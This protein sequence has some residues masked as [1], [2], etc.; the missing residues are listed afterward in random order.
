MSMDRKALED[1]FEMIADRYT[2]GELIDLLEDAGI[3]TVW[4]VIS[5]LEDEIIEGK[6]KLEFD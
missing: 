4:T 5:A 1:F 2:A 3:I 6:E